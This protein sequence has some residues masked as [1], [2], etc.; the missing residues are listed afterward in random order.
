[1]RSLGRDERLNVLSDINPEVAQFLVEEYANEACPSDG[2]V[3][4]KIRRYHFQ[5]NLNFEMRWWARLRGNRAQNLRS[6][7]RHD[8]IRAAFDALLDL[9]GLWYGMQ[10]S[11]IHKMMGLRFDE[12]SKTS[13]HH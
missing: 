9:P 2:E 4:C 12:V 6:L 13:L 3:Y 1:M 7:L 8:E 11:T 5:R 10:L